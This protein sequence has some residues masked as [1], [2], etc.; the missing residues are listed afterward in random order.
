MQGRRLVLGRVAILTAARILL[1]VSA[2]RYSLL[3]ARRLDLVLRIL[4]ELQ[5]GGRI[6]GQRLLVSDFGCTSLLLQI[7][8]FRA[9]IVDKIDQIIRVQVVQQLVR[10]GMVRFVLR[11]PIPLILLLASRGRGS[12]LTAVMRPLLQIILLMVVN[13]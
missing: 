5:S 1:R 9:T 13:R 6:L 2:G 3:A 10:H 12:L 11:S 4:L 8:T 7:L